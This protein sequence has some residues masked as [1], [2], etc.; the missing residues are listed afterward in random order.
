[1]KKITVLSVACLG[2]AAL[3]LVAQTLPS[4]G[5]P[6]TTTNTV[7]T[8]PGRVV[9]SRTPTTPAAQVPALPS[10]QTPPAV[11]PANQIVPQVPA[12]TPSGPGVPTGQMAPSAPGAATRTA[13]AVIP[14]E[15]LRFSNMEMMQFL[16]L[17]AEHV[18]KTLIYG[19]QLTGLL[20]NQVTL[21]IQT[22]LTKAELIQAMESVLAQNG[23]AIVPMGDK[24]ATVVPEALVFQQGARF[25]TS[26]IDQIAEAQTF[27]TQV[28]TLTNAL[29]SEMQAVLK[30]F[31]KVPNGILAIDGTRK[32]IIRD[33]AVNIRRMVELIHQLDV[34]IPMEVEL[35][36]IPIRFAL[37][38]DMAS[39]LGSLTSGGAVSSPN[40]TSR[41]RT[42]G[43]GTTGRTGNTGGG[44]GVGGNNTGGGI[45]GLQNQARPGQ[46]NVP[47]Q[48]S[49]FQNQLA[50][51]VNR[52]AQG[53]NSPILGDAKI[54]PD[55]RT[56]SL[57]V[58]GTKE[59]RK[60]IKDII[61]KL[62]VVQQQV[63]IEAVIME[64]SLSDNLNFG[65]SAAH[66]TS[67]DK[68][69]KRIFGGSRF[70]DFGSLTNFPGGLDNGFSYFGQLGSWDLAVNAIAGD[71]SV[72]VL[73][74][75]RIQTS[76]AV[77]A[78][79]FVGQTVPF[80]TGSTTD[81]NGGA[82]SQFSNQQ[83]GITLQ[84]L[85]LINNEGLVVL[86][87]VQ[88][89]AQLGEDRI[90]DGNAV[91][92]TTERNANA[93]VAVKNGETVILGGFISSNKRKT[94]TGVPF[95]K[96]IPVL[97]ALFSQRIDDNQRVELIVLIRPTVLKDPTIASQVAESER[98]RLSGVRRAEAEILKEEGELAVKSE[99]EME[100]M[101]KSKKP[102]AKDEMLVP[103]S[104]LQDGPNTVDPAA[105][106][107]AAPLK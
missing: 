55:E 7:P 38:A 13:E 60:M 69:S 81:I 107:P 27:D 43:L 51:I 28:V 86:D 102:I 2:A 85:P 47:G 98:Q 56:N 33:Y 45:Q 66:A 42:G 57:L 4:P 23:V 10:A 67:F 90:I 80:I 76:H 26:T 84:V 82:R 16:D 32:L 101:R 49:A 3:N 77:E 36:L 52:A 106:K 105:P 53:G 35:E 104:P 58:F 20:K 44:L 50:S 17:Y 88:S 5:S 29:P 54:I 89:V 100:K 46:P 103:G 78:S 34:N 14:I 30:D 15:E 62:D 19:Q 18:G 79:L 95:L 99:K 64:V 96:D 63:L 31:S 70:T 39:V 74:R 40:S 1:M 8:L 61:D 92:T 59:E 71:G 72:N 93:R 48:Q 9:P 37:S 75:P 73:S 22:P 94:K 83:V 91:P 65:V 21:K 68:G 97:G 12:P 11:T 41:N 6:A 87:I 24:F 25:K